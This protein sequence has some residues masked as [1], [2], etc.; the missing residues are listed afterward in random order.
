MA[1]QS[2]LHC[3]ML[4]K[5]G[6]SVGVHVSA[7]CCCQLGDRDSCRTSA[8]QGAHNVNAAG[9]AGL[10]D[11]HTAHVA[12]NP[13]G[14]SVLPLVVCIHSCTKVLHTKHIH[15][16][17]LLFPVGHSCHDPEPSAMPQIVL[18]KCK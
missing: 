16:L 4:C 14:F 15:R 5:A 12:A 2:G 17:V 13:D 7:V 18:F 8:L 6:L 9:N 11:L 3:L 10:K 1:S